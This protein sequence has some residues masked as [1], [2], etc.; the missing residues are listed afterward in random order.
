LAFLIYNAASFKD[1]LN[2]VR[3]A[4]FQYPAVGGVHT[5]D[6]RLP[7]VLF[8]AY[9][10]FLCRF[11]NVP[12]LGGFKRHT[13]LSPSLDNSSSQLVHVSFN[14]QHNLI[15]AIWLLKERGPVFL[16]VWNA[17]LDALAREES[18]KTM[19]FT[20]RHDTATEARDPPDFNSNT[21][22]AYRLTQQVLELL[23]DRNLVLDTYGFLAV[24][25]STENVG[26][27]CW[28]ILAQDYETNQAATESSN[29]SDNPVSR[30]ALDVQELLV[31]QRPRG[32]LEHYFRL[33]VGNKS[34]K[35]PNVTTN[36]PDP[37]TL[38]D[39][40]A[41][42]PSLPPYLTIPEPALLHA[43]I[44]ALGWHGSHAS[45]LTTLRWMAKYQ[46][47]LAETCKQ[48]HNGA[49]LMRRTIVAARVFL[50]RSWLPAKSGE[51]CDLAER[52]AYK[53]EALKRLEARALDVQIEEARALVDG[54][55]GWGG[56]PTDGDVAV[57]CWGEK[58]F[59]EFR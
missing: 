2:C 38:D 29:A 9:V 50:E 24:C 30:S 46:N 56:W 15:Q 21:I 34:F 5:L 51:G 43:Y 8:F 4:E 31:V 25:R 59:K 52:K 28:A 13:L 11:S 53:P 37:F 55:E 19:H 22:I 40:P 36:T 42:S 49:K 48:A 54:V 20:E 41:S 23:R 6:A 3:T 39:T 7:D 10:K 33:L 12:A 44:R 1:G 57:Y 14:F 26:I 16:P 45:I 35:E 58:R 47:E 32:R 17:V 27:A 18:Y